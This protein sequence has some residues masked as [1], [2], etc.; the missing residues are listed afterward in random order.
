MAFFVQ[1]I[2]QLTRTNFIHR[3][4]TD[5]VTYD[6]VLRRSIRHQVDFSIHSSFSPILD[7]VYHGAQHDTNLDKTERRIRN[8]TT[9]NDI[10]TDPK[11][12]ISTTMMTI[13]MI[14]TDDN[15]DG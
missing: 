11:T 4:L 8:N 15:D 14:V 5:S 1:S 13:M 3:K 2:L 7:T 12:I 9:Q 6:I 10:G